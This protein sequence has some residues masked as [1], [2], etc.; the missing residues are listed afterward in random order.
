MKRFIKLLLN[1]TRSFIFRVSLKT[2]LTALLYGHLFC[3]DFDREIVAFLEGKR[4]YEM[5]ASGSDSSIALLRRNTHRLEKGLIMQPRR[6]MFAQG[7]IVET[8]ESFIKQSRSGQAPE[9]IQW[10]QDV[11][12]TYFSAVTLPEKLAYLEK[13]FRAVVS[14]SEEKHL[15]TPYPRSESPVLS[16]LYE[17][18]FQLCLRRRSVRWYEDKQVPRE[19]IDKAIDAARYSPSACNRQPFEFYI[20]DDPKRASEVGAIPMGTVG[21]SSN[22]PAFI[23]LVG[24]MNNYPYARDRHLIYVDGA[25]ASMSLMF[26]LE[27]LGLASCPINWPD[28]DSLEK[29]MAK[30]LQLKPYQ[31]PVMCL[32]LGYAKDEGGVPFSSKKTVSKIRRYLD[33]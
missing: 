30:E 33:Q 28:I 17:D 2:R 4:Q 31:R 21:F 22:F 5:E 11:L 3:R 9:T 19:L 16:V 10:A 1:R 6:P 8:V 15:S 18:F 24:N 29:K 32:S 14:H 12:S 27:T 20:I 26:A 23:V 13:D 25:L 7:Y